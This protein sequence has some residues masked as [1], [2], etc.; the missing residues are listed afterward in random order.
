MTAT[1]LAL[2]AGLP[3]AGA[4]GRVGRLADR[5]RAR[6]FAVEVIGPEGEPAATVEAPPPGRRLGRAWAVRRLA[7][8]CRPDIL[9]V[10]TAEADALGLALADRWLVPYVLTVD[11]FLA[12]GGRL[13]LGRRSCRSI[14]A[15]TPEL[16]E[17]LNAA[18]VPRGWIAVVAP[19]IEPRPGRSTPRGVPVVATAGALAAGSG[20]ATF[21]D[22]A[23][24]VLASGATAEFVV[25]GEGPAE[26]DLRR[27]AERLGVADRVTFAARPGAE[28]AFWRLPAA[29]CQPSTRPD[30]GR[31][32]VTA[33][34]HGLPSAVADVPGLRGWVD[35]GVTG[36]LVPPGD[37][38][39]LAVAILG[40]LADTP[41]ADALGIAARRAVADRCDPDRQAD[42]LADLYRAVLADPAPTPPPAATRRS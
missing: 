5:L 9:H 17:D 2:L 24:R 27:A 13:R 42:A 39:A 37:P 15:T 18:G 32:L 7:E 40:L 34:A 36:V 12:P 21:L 4:S 28:A 25:A 19:G 33:L 31:T 6:G 29:Y 20:V 8:A 3:A 26:P 41:R 16:A 30:A 22:A 23:R 1:R 14:V 35:P 10:L 38:E 11:E